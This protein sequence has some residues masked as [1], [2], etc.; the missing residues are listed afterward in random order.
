[1][2][3]WVTIM[4]L[5]VAWATQGQTQSCCKY[6]TVYGNIWDTSIVLQVPRDNI[7]PT[8]KGLRASINHIEETFE[9]LYFNIV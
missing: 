8:K 9:Y 6:M 3:G 5:L 1:M 7:N 4:A 2:K